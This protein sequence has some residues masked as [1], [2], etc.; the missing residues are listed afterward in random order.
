[1]QIKLVAFKG[2]SVNVKDAK[3]IDIKNPNIVTT[4]IMTF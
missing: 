2:T 1:M 4:L 3:E